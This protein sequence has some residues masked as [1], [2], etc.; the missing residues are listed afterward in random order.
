MELSINLGYIR[1]GRAAKTKRTL[2][3]AAR[4]CR[5]G[6][7][8]YVNYISNFETEDWEEQ[9][10]RDREILDNA[11]IIVE[12]S[13]APYNRYGVYESND[14]FIEM[15]RRSF[16]CAHILGSKNVVVHA[17]EYHVTDRWDVKEIIECTY[18][19]LSPAA[20]YCAKNG[21]NLAI[22]NVFEDGS[23]RHPPFDGKSRFCSRLDEHIGIIERFASPNVRACWDFGHASCAYGKETMTEALRTIGKYL[24]CTHVHDNNKR[25]DQH[26]MPYMGEINWY[27]QMT[28][29]K[30][31]GYKGL[32][33]YEFVY[34]DIQDEHIS[35]W[36][37]L[38]NEVGEK[39]IGMYNEARE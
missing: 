18:D 11:G 24:V 19:Y 22:E 6:G 2:E 21:M 23:K 7:I 38:L 30:E 39:L 4:L 33:S 13:H 17:D 32:L 29:L 12:Q 14:R 26:L 25:S 20:E 31:V 16:I 27:E 9:A 34:G 10:H 28:C 5:E 15:L 1:G 3:T 35:T 8:R 36:M 37:K